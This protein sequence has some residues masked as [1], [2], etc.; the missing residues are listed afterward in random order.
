MLNVS[1]GHRKWIHIP[2][3]QSMIYKNGHQT[4]NYYSTGRQINEIYAIL[5]KIIR[6]EARAALTLACL[7]PSLGKFGVMEATYKYKIIPH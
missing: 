1:F 4:E 5:N 3:R 2:S 6:N 7:S